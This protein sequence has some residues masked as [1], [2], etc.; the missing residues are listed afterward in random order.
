MSRI[1]KALAGAFVT[2]LANCLMGHI[3]QACLFEA[4]GARCPRRRSA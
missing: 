4:L 2:A 1:N 3:L